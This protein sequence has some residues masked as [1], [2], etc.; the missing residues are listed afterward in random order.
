MA[1][2]IELFGKVMC[3]CDFPENKKLIGIGMSEHP[4]Y[5]DVLSSKF[6]FTNTFFHAEPFLDI[7]SKGYLPFR[8]LDFITCTEVFEHIVQPV[9]VGFDNLFRILKPG[10]KVIFSAPY[11]ANEKTIEH[12]PD[13]HD[14]ETVKTKKGWAV[15]NKTVAGE[16]QVFDS[17]VFHGGP[18]EVLEMRIYSEQDLVGLFEEAGFVDVKIYSET[19]MSIGYFWR[20]SIGS[21]Y[22]MSATKPR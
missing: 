15:L 9:S 16:W 18:G 7:T 20:E 12:Y 5:A 10:G 11:G 13:L 8:D 19:E 17:P 3:I 6:S 2:S 1:L 22:V 21:A 4:A 14:Y